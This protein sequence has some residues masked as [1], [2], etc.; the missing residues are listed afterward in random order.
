MEVGVV[1]PDFT[2]NT[3]LLEDGQMKLFNRKG[4]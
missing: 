2:R 4:V 1:K 3:K